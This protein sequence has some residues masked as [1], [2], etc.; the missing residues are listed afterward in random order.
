M[1]NQNETIRKS[2]EDAEIFFESQ[3]LSELERKARAE[4][5]TIYTESDLIDA[6]NSAY[7]RGYRDGSNDA[8]VVYEE[9]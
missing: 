8:V 9:V 6:S 4:L 1:N 5:E 7:A 3:R 2:K